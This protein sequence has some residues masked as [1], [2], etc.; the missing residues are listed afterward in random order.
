MISANTFRFRLGPI[1]V[2]LTTISLSFNSISGDARCASFSVLIGCP[3]Y[4]IVHA[5]A[6]DTSAKRGDCIELFCSHRTRGQ[7][8]TPQRMPRRLW[9]SPGTV[10]T[11]PRGACRQRSR[12]EYGTGL[13]IRRK[14]TPLASIGSLSFRRVPT[15]SPSKLPGSGFQT[16]RCHHRWRSPYSG[17]QADSGA[18]ITSVEVSASDVGAEVNTRLG[19][20]GSHLAMQISEL[21]SLT[22]NPYDFVN[23]SAASQPTQWFTGAASACLQRTRAASTEFCWMAWRTSICFR[24]A[25][26]RLSPRLRQRVPDCHQWLRCTVC[27]L[28]AYCEPVTKSGTNKYHG[29]LYEFNASRRWPQTL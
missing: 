26:P 22:R 14:P 25:S 9:F 19:G 12:I 4:Q 3:H 16:K 13:T 28:P 23:L 20:L 7:H 15:W 2:P 27:A 29:T 5:F 17:R 6:F 1:S 8:N 24:R 11:A 10:S 18:Q 21:P